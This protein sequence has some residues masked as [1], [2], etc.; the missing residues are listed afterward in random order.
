MAK[1][2]PATTTPTASTSDVSAP[3]SVAAITTMAP[4]ERV[5]LYVSTERRVNASFLLQGKILSTL[6]KAEALLKAA[7]I[8]PTSLSNARCAEWVLSTLPA[9]DKPVL[10]ATGN[11]A[12]TE[13]F[14]EGFYDQLTLRQCEILRKSLTLIGTVKHRPTVTE[15]R[16]ICAAHADWDDQLESFLETGLTLAGLAAREVAQ[17]QE[18]AAERQRIADMESSMAAMQQ[19]IAAQAAQ[20][21]ANPPPPPPVVTAPVVVAAVAAAT[22]VE[23]PAN[24]VAFT[25]PVAE[26]E[27]ETDQT[28]QTSQTEAEQEQEQEQEQPAK[29]ETEP[30]EDITPEDV[31]SAVADATENMPST[32]GILEYIN[33]L[34]DNMVDCIE[35]ADLSELRTWEGEL[36]QMLD[37]VRTHI[38]AKA[39]PQADIPA[40]TKRSGKKQRVA[41]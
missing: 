39:E 16:A 8:K 4:A 11:G 3:L 29:E 25:A 34:Q 36:Q 13:P 26:D 18:A 10:F 7:G 9:L 32:E 38:A 27:E 40:T 30:T 33:E 5:N 20:A 14:T 1:T 41:A 2:K 15:S 35:I 22:A 31:G 23:T 37:L 12:E 24:V 19:Q 6:D 21:A 17:A 28:D